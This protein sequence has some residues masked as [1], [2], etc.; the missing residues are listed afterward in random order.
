MVK[1]KTPEEEVLEK[2]VVVENDD[3]EEIF[4]GL[5]ADFD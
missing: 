2:E 4:E 1:K 5:D 3:G